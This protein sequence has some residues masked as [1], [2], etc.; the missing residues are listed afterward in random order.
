MWELPCQC[1]M[2][3]YMKSGILQPTCQ[4]IISTSTRWD[5]F[6]H[7]NG[8]RKKFLP[9]IALVLRC[10]FAFCLFLSSFQLGCLFPHSF[11][12]ITL[13]LAK[14][15][16]KF[17]RYRE[18]FLTKKSW[19]CVWFKQSPNFN[20]LCWKLAINNS[21]IWDLLYA[22][23][24]RIQ[25]LRFDWKV[26]RLNLVKSLKLQICRFYPFQLKLIFNSK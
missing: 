8:F 18:N 5:T 2:F 11:D 19:V 7:Y 1:L 6:K 26:A 16:W 14:V 23:R 25:G 15:Q 9:L 24:V 3:S 13:E 12:W 22:D 21:G 10:A 4:L 20:L 17:C